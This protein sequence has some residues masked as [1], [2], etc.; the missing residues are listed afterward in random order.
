MQ[1]TSSFHR[2]R[3]ENSNN[4]D[5]LEH[6]LNFSGESKDGTDSFNNRD[7]TEDS[8][9]REVTQ[10]PPLDIAQIGRVSVL[11]KQ[12]KRTPSSGVLEDLLLA[13]LQIDLDLV[14]RIIKG[15]WDLNVLGK[16]GEG[17]LHVAAKTGSKEICRSLIRS[18]ARLH[19]LDHNGSTPANVAALLGKLSEF[20][21]AVTEELLNAAS[22]NDEE[23]LK[24]L[25]EDDWDI[26]SK[27]SHGLT[28]LH[29]AA[30]Q[31][32]KYICQYLIKN[33][34]KINEKDV[35][36]ET[37]LQKAKAKGQSGV[38]DYLKDKGAETNTSSFTGNNMRRKQDVKS[39]S[40]IQKTVNRLSVLLFWDKQK[41]EKTKSGHFK[42]SEDL[43][44][45]RNLDIV[46]HQGPSTPE[47]KKKHISSLSSVFREIYR[48]SILPTSGSSSPA[49][50]GSYDDYQ[51]NDEEHHRW[52]QF[53]DPRR[54]AGSCIKKTMHHDNTLI[55]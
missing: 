9:Q 45:S 42:L 6:G 13:I 38:V 20:N 11:S 16:D 21:E 24:L 2:R 44:T 10:N 1:T 22:N 34:A 39:H 41:R 18:G 50:T 37:A 26:N 31:G 5:N 47:P 17:P 55:D 7:E 40:S 27:D 30:G 46:S 29:K 53:L 8:Y 14:N 43:Y 51:C 19:F 49:S 23:I 15:S 52:G 54:R 4:D 3:V 48:T 33:G 32:H 25:I 35:E 36:N 28:A 12:E